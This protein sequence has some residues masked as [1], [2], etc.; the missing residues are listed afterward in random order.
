MTTPDRR[1]R[2]GLSTTAAGLAVPTAPERSRKRDGLEDPLVAWSA[3]IGVTLLA[4]FLRLWHLGSPKEFE[5][6]ETYYAK[7][8]WSMANHGYVRNYVDDAN[9]LI[10]GGQTTDVWKSDPSMIVHPEVGKWLIALGEKAFG[11]DPFGWRISAAVVGALMVL[12]MCRLARRL[13][14]STA[15]GCVAG[16]LLSLDGL[17]FVLSRLALLDIFLAFFLL[18]G[19]HCVVADRDHY[20][21]R[22]AAAV[23]AGDGVPATGWGPVRPVLFRPWLVL[24][25]V[26]FGL[27]I[28]TK[29]TAA[30]PMAAFGTM[31]WLWS[32]GARR[33]FG[34]RWPVLR[35]ALVDGA[36][37]FAQLVLVA[38]VVYVGTWTGWLMHAGEYEE[39]LSSSQYTRFV[40]EGAT[41]EDEP[42]LNDDRW[43]TASEPD[44]TGPAEGVQS[45]RSLW[46]YHQDLF[47]FH[48]H[49]LNCSD[50]TYGSKPLGW[51]LLNRPVGVAADTG[52]EPGT[53]GCDAPA[54]STCLRQVLLIGT[55][56]L[57]WGGIVALLYGLAMWIGARDWRFGVAIVGTAST[58]LPWLR[59]DDRPIFLFYAIATLPFIVL[60]LTLA[61][62]KL[63]GRS[64]PSSPRR[65]AGVIVAGSFF[66]LVLV[67]FAWFWP[68]YTNELLTR[69][70]WLDR[71]WF[72]RWI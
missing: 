16:L 7:D 61:M 38:F 62:G 3:A 28:G 39:H 44:A 4:L 29:W 52:I 43:P 63:V 9:E 60:A 11:M 2:K 30:F 68:I 67:N 69:S 47:T 26:C 56:V 10:L 49:F 64:R 18:C 33:S 34:V 36:P 71:I 20:R 27:A 14:G 65:T 72:T 37:A 8:A 15:L 55:P 46:S 45:L 70:E 50:H 13:T 66:V 53:R 41:C 6:D 17:H 48:T 1:S 57:W 25:G 54:G 59:Y 40:A 24:A 22:L 12:V 32:A 5:F 23:E 35:S 51:L 42:V 31:V 21:A 58:W 19:V